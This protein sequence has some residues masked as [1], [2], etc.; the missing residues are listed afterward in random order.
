MTW[1]WPG[2]WIAAQLGDVATTLASLRFGGVESN[3]FVL[4]LLSGGGI[5]AYL[6]VK[7]SAIAVGAC[8][9]YLADWLRRWLP[10]RIA[11][12][13]SRTF[14]AGLQIAIAVQLLAVAANLI[15]LR[16]ELIG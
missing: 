10:D 3:P 7:L 8:L 16:A 5:G 14:V 12:Q 9:L 2:L 13:V 1:L 6:T 15:V 4:G 11:V